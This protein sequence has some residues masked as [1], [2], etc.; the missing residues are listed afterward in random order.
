MGGTSIVIRTM[1]ESSGGILVP[2]GSTVFGVLLVRSGVMRRCFA[3]T[4]PPHLCWKIVQCHESCWDLLCSLSGSPRY[5]ISGSAVP[6]ISPSLSGV[7]ETVSVPMSG[8]SVLQ[9]QLSPVLALVPSDA[10]TV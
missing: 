5:Q 2:Y 7:A 9:G 4:P 8:P 10:V 3:P 1:V 6:T